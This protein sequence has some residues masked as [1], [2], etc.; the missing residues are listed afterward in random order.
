MSDQFWLQKG[1]RVE[2]VKE[3]GYPGTIKEI[4]LDCHPLFEYGVTT[5][6]VTWDDG[7]ED[8]KWTNKLYKIDICFQEAASLSGGIRQ[9]ED[10]Q[11]AI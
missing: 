2:H 11:T 9:I 3:V 6:I 7:G 8:I 10:R 5:C 4:D 1:D